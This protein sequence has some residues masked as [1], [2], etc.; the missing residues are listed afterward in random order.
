MAEGTLL[1]A[2]LEAAIGILT[3]LCQANKE[4]EETFTGSFLGALV[5]AGGILASFDQTTGDS[6]IWWSS[7]GK[8]R[9][10]DTLLS[11]AG[12]GADFALLLM[13]E[14]GKARL[15][16]FQAKRSEIHQDDEELPPGEATQF[17]DFNR[18]PSK[19][20]DGVK[21]EPQMF[22]LVETGRRIL[23]G[24]DKNTYLANNRDELVE[25][26]K[27]P[28]VDPVSAGGLAELDWIHYL[29]YT[30]GAPSCVPLCDLGNEYRK[31]V[32]RVKSVTK[33][34]LP[35]KSEPVLDLLSRGCKEKH[36]GW[37]PISFDEAVSYLPL[38][39]PLMPVVVGDA[40]GT[41]GPVISHG[42]DADKK[43]QPLK[44]SIGR[45]E[46]AR[47]LSNAREKMSAPTASSYKNKSTM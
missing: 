45:G 21:R 28:D 23:A 9:G 16:I 29:I 32:R 4:N 19:R 36:K 10:G 30:P 20:K 22:V 43:I 1:N 14:P 6:P 34:V 44:L 37:L 12:S 13:P 33:Y 8:F 31:E 47:F 39:T 35:G 25:L 5:A 24:L 11:E 40:T 15:S 38:L 42:N 17:V 7:Y 26:F 18:I 41:F 27:D 2:S 3:S 46:F